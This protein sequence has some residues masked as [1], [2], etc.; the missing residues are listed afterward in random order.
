[1]A[2][3]VWH[4]RLSTTRSKISAT[5]LLPG[6]GEFLGENAQEEVS[7]FSRLEGT[8]QDDIATRLQ[9]QPL[10]HLSSVGE[11]AR[12]TGTVVVVHPLLCQYVAAIIRGLRESGN[13]I[14]NNENTKWTGVEYQVPGAYKSPKAAKE[15]APNCVQRH[16]LK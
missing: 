6:F 11:G 5:V 16:S 2:A 8:G 3:N 4:I 9:I 7:L 13:G 1:M 10:L 15:G 14:W 12:R